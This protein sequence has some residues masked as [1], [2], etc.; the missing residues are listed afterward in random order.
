M[1]NNPDK[2]NPYMAFILS[3]KMTDQVTPDNIEYMSDDLD[4]NELNDMMRDLIQ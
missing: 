1:G 4:Y 3:Q 2:N